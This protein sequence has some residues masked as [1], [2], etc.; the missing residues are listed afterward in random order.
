MALPGK[1]HIAPV[2]L[3][4][5]LIDRR[6]SRLSRDRAMVSLLALSHDTCDLR[7]P[8]QHLFDKTLLQHKGQEGTLRQGRRFVA[9]VPL[10][11]NVVL[12]RLNTIEPFL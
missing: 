4:E 1:Y 5:V 10:F 6:R 3:C 7:F 9:V 8:Q 12:I 2:G 11:D